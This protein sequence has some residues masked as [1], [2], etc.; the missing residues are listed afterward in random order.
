MAA[1]WDLLL[2]TGTGVAL[3]DMLPACTIRFELDRASKVTFSDGS[4]T[5]KA[6][7]TLFEQLQA[8]WPQLRAM[9][10]DTLPESLRFSGRLDPTSGQADA[11]G[12]TSTIAFRSGFAML[13]S[14]Y[15]TSAFT[16][17]DAGQVAKALIDAA[18]TDHPTGVRVGSVETTL[19]LSRS[20]QLQGV[21]D[22]I[23]GMC[24]TDVQGGF[25]F[26]EQPLD[27]TE[28]AGDL[29]EL[30]IVSGLGVDK[31]TSVRL[32]YGK[33]TLANTKTV[34]RSVKQ[35]INHVTTTVNGVV[36]VV[37]DAESI[38]R[39]G[40]WE[41]VEQTSDARDNADLLARAEA[42]LVPDPVEVVTFEPDPDL[43]PQPFEDYWLGDTVGFLAD[44]D[45]LQVDQ[46][47]RI[48]AIEIDV[49]N[50]SETAHRLEY[51]QQR[52]RDLPKRIHDLER[53]VAFL[54]RQ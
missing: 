22:A 9:R 11:N 23:T 41:L 29:S 37:F 35:P 6:I 53:K 52:R 5:D 24:G 30:R 43:A 21:A 47:A 36:A 15:T 14:R 10:R 17:Q 4:H 32:E 28:Q 44:A 26:D 49:K 46:T 12:G 2:C 48:I 18:N 27:P 50:G 34:T 3:T 20:Y 16:D 19:T 25:D 54:E 39:Y 38:A 33:G 31:S 7:V 42:L 1:P 8:G 13:E 40:R 51:G 45:A